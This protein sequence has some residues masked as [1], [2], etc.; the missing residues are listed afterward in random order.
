MTVYD[1]KD[2]TPGMLLMKRERGEPTQ[3]IWR[4]LNLGAHHITFP[5]KDGSLNTPKA[6]LDLNTSFNQYLKTK[7]APDIPNPS[8]SRR[9]GMPRVASWLAWEGGYSWMDL[10]PGYVFYRVYDTW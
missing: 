4:T 7:N 9:L 6:A 10:V 2:S 3:I 8:F 1:I 5:P